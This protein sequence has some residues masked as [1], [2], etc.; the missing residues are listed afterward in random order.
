MSDTTTPAPGW[1]DIEAHAGFAGLRGVVQEKLIPALE[2]APAE[3]ASKSGAPKKLQRMMSGAFALG[4]ALFLS[5]FFILPD[6]WWGTTLR[7]IAFPLCFFGSIVLFARLNWRVLMEFFLRAE[8]RLGLRAEG[9]QAVAGHLGL[10]Y[11]PMPGGPPEGLA[12]LARQSW[13]PGEFRQLVS[14]M[15]QHGGMDD[16]VEA[17]RRA[18]LMVPNVV[19]LGNEETKDKYR[20]QQEASQELEDGFHGERNG[21]GFDMF[22]WV[23]HVSDAP[24]IHH[25]VVVLKAPFAL[26][27]VTE[28]RSRHIGWLRGPDKV[29]LRPVSLEAV[30]FADHYRLRSSDQVESRALFNPAVIERVL[31]L[32]DRGKFRGVASGRDLVFAFEGTDRF[33][34]LNLQTGAWDET[35]IRRGLGDL[36]DALGL[37]DALAHAFMLRRG[38]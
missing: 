10:N 6:T 21:I 22:E 11:V 24:N 4:V 12:M 34:L 9:L 16:A 35:S 32:A 17:A 3:D 28:L 31:A 5:T 25:L 1:D 18:G 2:R 27:G 38:A 33:A 36:A 7:F 30:R 8:T 26:E 29:N 19:V 23:E 15:E 14:R 13:M 37:V 20:A